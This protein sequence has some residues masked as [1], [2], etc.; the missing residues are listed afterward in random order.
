MS[1]AWP[2]SVSL[3][4]LACSAAPQSVSRSAASRGITI[5]AADIA[6]AV[7]QTDT[8]AVVDAM[9]RLVPIAGEYNVGVS[10]VR[11]SQ[12]DG[13][14]P[15]DANVHEAITEVYYIVEGRGLLVTGGTVDDAAPLLP[16]DPLVLHVIGPSAE[17][18]RISGG[19]QQEVGPGDIVIIPPHTAH[20]FA[21]LQTPRVVYVLVRIDPH[22]VLRP[23]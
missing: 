3:L 12:V 1:F 23:K 13:V 11:R 10:V 8:A 22:R 18:K 4:L 5:K 19:A 17:G 15:P 20:G 21:E 7:E 2:R 16:D 9:L 6:S 14:T